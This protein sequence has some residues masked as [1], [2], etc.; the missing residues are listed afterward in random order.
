MRSFATDKIALYFMKQDI[1]RKHLTLLYS[2]LN[3]KMY[4]QKRY[5]KIKFGDLSYHFSL[6]ATLFYSLSMSFS[7]SLPLRPSLYPSPLLLQNKIKVLV[8][9]NTF[10]CNY[11]HLTYKGGLEQLSRL[12]NNHNIVVKNA[13]YKLLLQ[14]VR[15][16]L[17]ADI[18]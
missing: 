17:R 1:N 15:E 2:L 10:H 4:R 12:A 16:V 13:I 5:V 8:A 3:F 9:L 7:L 14:L 6:Y 11:P 18:Y